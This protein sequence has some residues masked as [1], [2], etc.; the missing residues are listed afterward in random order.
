VSEKGAADVIHVVVANFDEHG[1]PVDPVEEGLNEQVKLIPRANTKTAEMEFKCQLAPAQ[2]VTLC[3]LAHLWDLEEEHLPRGFTAADFPTRTVGIIAT[4]NDL[5]L[6]GDMIFTDPPVYE[7]RASL[8]YK[9]DWKPQCYITG[10]RTV[11]SDFP[12]TVRGFLDAAFRMPGVTRVHEEVYFEDPAIGSGV[13]RRKSF[14][15]AL[16][17]EETVSERI[18]LHGGHYDLMFNRSPVCFKRVSILRHDEWVSEETKFAEQVREAG[19]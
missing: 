1:R 14:E 17:F 2:P 11:K 19:C 16:S 4:P 9:H 8:L 7:A 5:E 13:F 12:L 6:Y 18:R 3:P 10:E 15:E